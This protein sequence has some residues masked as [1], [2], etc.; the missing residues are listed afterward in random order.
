VKILLLHAFPLDPSM[1]EAQRPVLEGHGVAAPSLY[2]RGNEMDAW[3]DSLLLELDGPFDCC[4]GASMGGGCALALERKSPGLLG[5][6]VLAGAHA[7]PDA[8][9]RRAFREQ[10]LAEL[11]AEGD[12]EKA[13]IVEALRDRP[14][15]RALLA[16]FV[17]PVLVVVGDD[18]PMI[19]VDDARVLADSAQR[20]RLEVIAGAGHLVSVD[21]PDAFN[22]ALDSFLEEL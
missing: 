21:R 7:G 5:A 3:A 14:D 1:W 2:G 20:G 16:S 15:D 8:P 11:R 6:L 19:P 22:T 10:Q 18:D 13:A 12:E 4:V 17:G 9:E